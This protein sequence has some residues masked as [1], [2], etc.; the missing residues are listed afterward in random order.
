MLVGHCAVA[1]AAKRVEPRLSLGAL[2]AAAVLA[3]LLGFVFILV[4][5]EHWRMNAGSAGIYAVDLDSV[6]WSHGLL[7]NILWAALFAICSFLWRRHG[8]GAWILFGAVLSHWIL[9]FVSHRP[10]MPLSPGLSG[11]YGLGLWTSVP[12]TL[13]VEGLLWLMAI[14]VY[15]RSTRAS[16]RTGIYVFWAM[17]VFLTLS[18]V[19]N[20]TARPPAGSLTAASIASLA[21]FT[22]LVAWAYWID[23][24][25]KLEPNIV[26]LVK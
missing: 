13:V 3:D 6:P 10:D 22:L 2:M 25:R 21:F 12:A 8:A 5:I 9:D 16:K 23:R 19:N 15:V 18:W 4:G 17:I 14:A 1:M 7:P 20:L 24:V 11:R 26:S